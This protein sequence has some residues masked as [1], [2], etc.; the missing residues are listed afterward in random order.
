M[1]YMTWAR[2]LTFKSIR[3]LLCT[4]RLR[5]AAVPKGFCK[6]LKTIR[7]VKN[8]VSNSRYSRPYYYH[9]QYLCLESSSVTED[10]LQDMEC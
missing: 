8:F 6:E 5:H 7:R 4:I 1:S 2:H 9:D 3:F 10:L